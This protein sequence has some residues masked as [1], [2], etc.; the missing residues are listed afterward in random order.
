ML[1]LV[2]GGSI[3]RQEIPALC[4]RVRA[5]LECS[6]EGPVDCDVGALDPDAVSVDALARLQLTARRLGRTVRLRHSCG[7]LQELLALTGLREV[8]PLSVPLERDRD[9][10]DRQQRRDHEEQ[11]QRHV[12][13][14]P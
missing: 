6:G 13:G 5:T 14:G 8:L 3:A 1:V 11:E 4:E 10:G 2:L 9:A 12:G 7:E